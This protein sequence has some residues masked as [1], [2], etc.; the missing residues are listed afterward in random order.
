MRYGTTNDTANPAVTGT[1]D[2]LESISEGGSEQVGIPAAADGRS[3]MD[4]LG[5]GRCSEDAASG[6]G[7]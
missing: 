3:P 2:R 7:E 1:N 4:D 5:P 6:S